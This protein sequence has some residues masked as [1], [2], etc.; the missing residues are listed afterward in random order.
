MSTDQPPSLFVETSRQGGALF[1]RLVGPNIGTHEAPI[2]ATEVTG[3]LKNGSAV[4]HL[5]LDFTDVQFM[6][7]TG[8]GQCITMHNV[9]KAMG[10]K[11]IVYNMT[12]DLWQ[13]MKLTKLDKL[14]TVVNDEK[15]LEKVLRK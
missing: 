12:G 2:V 6:N 8:I 14:F 3:E 10:I 7:S 1:A 11:V 4:S 13:V 15:K 5:V 9:A